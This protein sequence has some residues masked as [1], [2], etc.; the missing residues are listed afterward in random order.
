MKRTLEQLR[1][2]AIEIPLT[3][4]MEQRARST[5][6]EQA[7]Q[8][9]LCVLA[10]AEYLE[11][12]QGYAIDLDASD[13]WSPILRRLDVADVPVKGLGRLECRLVQDEATLPQL[14]P[15]VWYDRIGYV[16]V[17]LQPGA[18]RLL[19]VVLPFDPEQQEIELEPIDTLL[20]HLERL[21]IAVPIVAAELTIDAGQQLAIVAQLER[22]YRQERSSRWGLRAEEVLTGRSLMG[23]MR[24]E[25][26]ESITYQ[27]L[28]E[29]LMEKLSVV[30]SELRG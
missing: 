23:T 21:A 28:A 6:D 15:E 26:K 30:W 7:E 14:P 22:I 29:R 9:A 17:Q 11:Q 20:E 5:G 3:T 25:S 8:N 16:H 27:E 1:E 24:E 13:V 19:G 4:R 18:A 2:D 12:W 10:V